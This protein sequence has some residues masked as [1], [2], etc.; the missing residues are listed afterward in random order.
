MTSKPS[1]PVSEALIA[2]A[3]E[4]LEKVGP[5]SMSVREVAS[6]AGVNHGQVHHYFGSKRGLV[7][8]AVL[9]LLG[10][11]APVV[12]SWAD[13]DPPHFDAQLRADTDRIGLVLSRMALDGYVD[14][15]IDACRLV[16]AEE[17]IEL[18]RL[19]ESK[20]DDAAQRVLSFVLYLGW[21]NFSELAM[22]A[23][24]IDLDDESVVAERVARL[25]A[26]MSDSVDAAAPDLAATEVVETPG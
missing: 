21:L 9:S 24:L 4:M 25:V 15:V 18:V 19:E 2:A 17:S 1:N 5:R 16:I 14:D 10:Q 8:A 20:V 7:Q 12:R 11:A 3:I 13:G 22:R 6:R 23:V 26:N